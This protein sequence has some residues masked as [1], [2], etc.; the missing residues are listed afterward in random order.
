MS[1]FEAS[2][3]NG[4]LIRTVLMLLAVVSL[5]AC[6]SQQWPATP[7]AL[8]E[9]AHFDGAQ[10][11]MS[12]GLAVRGKTAYLGYVGSGQVV[13]VDLDSGAVTPYSQ[14]PAPVA[15]KGFLAGLAVHGDEL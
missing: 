4:T 14:L 13:A 3:G 8:T 7:V 11:Q 1:R 12:E 9:V 2:S 6:A 15:G 10:G 5:A